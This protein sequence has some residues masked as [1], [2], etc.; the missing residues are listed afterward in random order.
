MRN[1][2]RIVIPESLAAGL[3][4]LLISAV[5][6]EKLAAGVVAHKKPV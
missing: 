2:I 4:G 3:I 1:Q 5:C 6:R